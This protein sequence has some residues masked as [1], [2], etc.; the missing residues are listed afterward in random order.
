LA[1]NGAE[2]GFVVS[3]IR[4]GYN[5]RRESYRLSFNAGITNLFNRFY[6][7]QFVFATARGRSFVLGTT[8]ELF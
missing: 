5:F 7:D 3:D 8:W 2:P 6:N 4:G 1:A